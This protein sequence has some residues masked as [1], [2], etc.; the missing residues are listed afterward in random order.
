M[1][2]PYFPSHFLN[3]EA[4]AEKPVTPSPTENHHAQPAPFD[5][6]REIT[7]G[8]GA[9]HALQVHVLQDSELFLA[10]KTSTNGDFMLIQW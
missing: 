9:N 6:G 7:D 8:G 5:G 1:V 4:N 10:E 2:F 3:R